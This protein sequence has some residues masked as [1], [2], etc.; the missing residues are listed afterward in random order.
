MIK[1]RGLEKGH[2]LGYQ[3]EQ[4]MELGDASDKDATPHAQGR[5]RCQNICSC[6]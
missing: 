5:E 1:K 4:M 3:F 6:K 2:T